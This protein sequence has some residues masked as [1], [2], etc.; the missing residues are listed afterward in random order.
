VRSDV[1]DVRDAAAIWRQSA[2]PVA[3]RPGG[4]PLLVKLPFAADNADW[5]RNGKRTKPE[6]VKRFK[7][8]EVPRSWFNDVIL[9]VLQRYGRV[10]VI[11][12]FR[13]LEKCAPACWNAQGFECECSCMGEHHGSQGAGAGW[14]VVS[15]T[16]AVRHGE[17]VLA[18]RLIET[19]ARARSP[20]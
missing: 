8:W 2:I 4:A 1:S 12:P 14:F 6:W 20:R 18:C 3:Y 9:R 17:R 19:R 13:E 10:Y 16:C 7:A 11:Q 15:E 5:L